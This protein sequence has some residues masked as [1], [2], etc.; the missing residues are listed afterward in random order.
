[1]HALS[2]L[3]WTVGYAVM[4]SCV[5]AVWQALGPGVLLRRATSTPTSRVLFGTAMLLAAV[6]LADNLEAMQLHSLSLGSDGVRTC[7]HACGG[8]PHWVS[9]LG[10]NKHM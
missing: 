2:L 1:M 7:L 10:L 8:D 5:C 3:H 4:E 9:S 6:G